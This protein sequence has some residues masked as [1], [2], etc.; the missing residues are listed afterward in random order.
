MIKRIN[1]ILK[2]INHES[3][4][5]SMCSNARNVLKVLEGGL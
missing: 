2:K 4:N 1:T 3:E 5:L